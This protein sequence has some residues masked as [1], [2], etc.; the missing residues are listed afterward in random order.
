MIVFDEGDAYRFVTQPDHAR[1]AGELM[2]LWREHGLPAHPRRDDLLFAVREHDN[3]WRE[4]DAAPRWNA[5]AG[6]PHDFLSVPG[7]VRLEV[8][9]RGT[10]RFAG[11][12]PYAALLVALHGLAL[13][14]WQSSGT[15]ESGGSGESSDPGGEAAAD[16]AAELEERAD[17]LAEAAG[18]ARSEAAADYPFLAFADAASLAVCNR[19]NE[20]FERPAPAA[21]GGGS[22]RGRFE[23]TTETL[24]LDPFPLAGATRFDIPVRRIEKRLYAGDADL[25]GELAAARW[26][27]LDVRVSPPRLP[28]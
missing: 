17:E 25:G 4:A 21:A 16:L 27:R 28:G 13:A 24:Y 9:R 5:A 19:W 6:R 23:P 12:R 8:W 7:E 20:P 11:E 1:F 10:E 14:G 15:G 3:G 26:G 18:V 2:S 22:L